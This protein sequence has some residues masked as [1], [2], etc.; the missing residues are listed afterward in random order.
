MSKRS[1]YWRVPIGVLAFLL[2]IVSLLPLEVGIVHVGV[3]VPAAVSLALL[4]GCI[5]YRPVVR[6]VRWIWQRPLWKGLFLLLTGLIAALLV[7]F[8]VV[9]GIMLYAASRPAPENATVIVLGAG[10][11]GD[12]PSRM[13]ADRL[14][15]AAHYLEKNPDS[16]CIVSGGQGAD[17]AYTEAFVMQQYLL[18]LGIDSSRILVEDQS[19]NTFENIQFSKAIIEEQGLNPTVVISTQEFH[20]YRGQTM[21]K[22]AGLTEVGPCTSRTPAY[23]LLGYWVREFAG[24]CR[25]WLLG[26]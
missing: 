10:I 16:V 8:V 24:I 6:V 1:L 13:L 15:A 17:E 9:S 26:Y 2:L 25:L 12:Q 21:A 19:R 22:T 5:V 14:R 23:L 20:Q 7:L 18:G 3:V 11:R 4:A